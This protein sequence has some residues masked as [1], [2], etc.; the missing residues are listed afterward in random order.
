MRVLVAL[1]LCVALSSLANADENKQ[2]FQQPT[3][4]VHWLDLGIVQGVHFSLAVPEQPNIVGIWRVA[5]LTTK[6]E[7]K[8]VKSG[9]AVDCEKQVISDDYASSRPLQFNK[10]RLA[11]EVESIKALCN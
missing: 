4:P 2:V 8:T 11:L 5:E 7:G 6:F 10:P 3:S 1:S 9:I